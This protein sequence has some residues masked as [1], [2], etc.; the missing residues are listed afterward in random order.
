MDQEWQKKVEHSR[1]E[2]KIVP[3]IGG[4]FFEIDGLRYVLFFNT[5]LLVGMRCDGQ[6]DEYR[7]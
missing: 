5:V 3:L 2:M 6:I 4:A 7:A 1:G